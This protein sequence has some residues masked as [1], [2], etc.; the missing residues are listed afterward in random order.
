MIE[1]STKYWQNIVHAIHK[2]VTHHG[3]CTVPMA[4]MSDHILGHNTEP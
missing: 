4:F 3:N 2:K 1:I